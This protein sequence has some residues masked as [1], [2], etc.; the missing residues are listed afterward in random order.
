MEAYM[1]LYATRLD[2][3]LFCWQLFVSHLKF[4]LLS[5]FSIIVVYPSTASH[6]N[7]IMYTSHGL[8]TSAMNVGFYSQVFLITH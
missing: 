2:I 5:V 6:V 3:V 4:F 7:N 8:P 1:V